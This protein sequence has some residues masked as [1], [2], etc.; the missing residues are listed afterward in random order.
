MYPGK[1]GYLGKQRYP[2]KQRIPRKTKT[3][4][5]INT[6][7]KTRL[8]KKTK[9]IQENKNT[10]GNKDIQENKGYPGKQE[11]PGT[12]GNPTRANTKENL[13][14]S[15]SISHSRENRRHQPDL[16]FWEH[17]FPKTSLALCMGPATNSSQIP[18]FGTTT[19]TDSSPAPPAQPPLPKVSMR[20]PVNPCLTLGNTKGSG[21]PLKFSRIAYSRLRSRENQSQAKE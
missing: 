13:G 16:R 17:S 6:S 19:G 5:E 9:D 3:S 12:Q 11:Y 20:S 4:M 7:R 8:P 21:I 10:Q 2:E 15:R 18:G 1:Q 14:K